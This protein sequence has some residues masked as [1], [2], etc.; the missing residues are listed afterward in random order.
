[1]PTDQEWREGLAKWEKAV[2]DRDTRIRGLK[3]QVARQKGEIDYRDD[4]IGIL[5]SLVQLWLLE[6]HLP[7]D[8]K[9]LIKRIAESLPF[10]PE[11]LERLAKEEGFHSS[12]DVIIPLPPEAGEGVKPPVGDAGNGNDKG[13]KPKA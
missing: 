6:P 10:F 7:G 2:E 12:V 3:D 9:Q 1:M 8:N 11:A 5:E 4:R 13:G